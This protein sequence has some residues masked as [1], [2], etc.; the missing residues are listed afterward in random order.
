VQWGRL[1]IWAFVVALAV[2]IIGAEIA[3]GL[4]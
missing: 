1:L 2:V 4:R 3:N